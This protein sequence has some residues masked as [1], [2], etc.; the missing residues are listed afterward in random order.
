MLRLTTYR[1]AARCNTRSLTTIGIRREDPARIWERRA[2]LTPKAVAALLTLGS[3][4][5]EVQVES[6]DKRC[7]PD[8]QY[9]HVS[10]QALLSDAEL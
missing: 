4:N 3:D 10:L 7:F 6:C 2:P 8:D 5:V 9:R 1:I